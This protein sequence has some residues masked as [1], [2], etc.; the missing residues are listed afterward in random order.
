MESH[1]P[2]SSDSVEKAFHVI[3]VTTVLVQKYS[4]VPVVIFLACALPAPGQ[5]HIYVADSED[6][7]ISV[8]DPL[9]SRVSGTIPVSPNPRSIV[10]SADGLRLY[11]SSGS[12]DVVEVIER[13]TGAISHTVAVGHAPGNLAISPDGRRLF[14]C[15]ASPP[16]IDIIDSALLRK[17][18]TIEFA[19]GPNDL[20]ITPDQT[21]IIAALP[22]KLAVINI[23]TEAPEFEIPVSGTPQTL[24]I[25]SDKNLVIHRL[26]VEVAGSNGFGI[27]DYG[28][29][30]AAGKIAAPAGSGLAISPD[31]NTLW[32]TGEADGLVTILSLPGLKRL[33]SILLGMKPDSIV[34]TPDGR[35]GFI[36]NAGSNSVS[37]IDVQAYKELARI[38]VGKAPRRMAAVQ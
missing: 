2:D 19:K 34:F 16:G 22:G 35:F 38:P 9:T 21:R 18:R 30:K 11:V 31:R 33:T 8:I 5:I 28:A 36:S 37:S 23:R 3:N 7:R 24:A 26:F 4:I 20:Y 14:L 13:R 10:A 27:I 15:I 32:V 12:K 6:N 17:V 29:R 1:A 25:D